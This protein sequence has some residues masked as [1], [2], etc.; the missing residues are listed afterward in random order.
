MTERVRIALWGTVAFV[1][2]ALAVPWFMWRSDAVIAG[3]PVWIW[4]HVGWLGLASV[5]FYVFTQR[6]WGLG[7]ERGEN[8]G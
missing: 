2:I 1:L 3:L 8:R 7:V 6:A 4:W 5:V